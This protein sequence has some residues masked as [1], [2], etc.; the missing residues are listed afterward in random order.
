MAIK[1]AFGDPEKVVKIWRVDWDISFQ[2][3]YSGT[4][5]PWN[6]EQQSSWISLAPL[7]EQ[8]EYYTKLQTVPTKSRDQLGHQ[9]SEHVSLLHNINNYE[10]S[11]IMEICKTAY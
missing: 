5:M 6:L 2:P 1:E 11:L 4:V 3:A 8:K 7:L 9:N 10:D